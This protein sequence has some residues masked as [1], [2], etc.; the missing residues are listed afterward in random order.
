MMPAWVLSGWRF[1]KPFAPYIGIAVAAF[2]A[3]LIAVNHG[4]SVQRE[5]DQAEIA[6]ITRDR[7]THASNERLLQGALDRQNAAMSALKA[8]ADRRAQ[9]GVKALEE[10]RKANAGLLE[11][12]ERL[13]K[14]A[15]L[16]YGKDDP[17][18]ISDALVR[19]GKI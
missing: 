4:K 15:G 18:V 6:A 19:A 10:A 11:Q 2:A 5:N 7:D 9:E 14:S 13:R 12:A 3:W 8:D 17:C 1:I 16:K